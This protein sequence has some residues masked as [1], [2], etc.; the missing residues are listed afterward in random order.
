MFYI[1]ARGCIL[2]DRLWIALPW[3][4]I[5]IIAPV[6]SYSSPQSNPPVVSQIRPGLQRSHSAVCR[7]TPS[8]STTS[9]EVTCHLG[10]GRVTRICFQHRKNTKEI[11]PERALSVAEQRVK[12]PITELETQ[13]PKRKINQLQKK[14]KTQ[15]QI[16]FNTQIPP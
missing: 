4:H 10:T 7:T 2:P 16:I 1:K 14:P 6:L 9:N 3:C 11:P 13:L 12:V 8:S 5:S 15:F